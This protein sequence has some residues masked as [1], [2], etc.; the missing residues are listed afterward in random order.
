MPVVANNVGFEMSVSARKDGALRAAYVR[1][2]QGRVAKTR[3]IVE[4]VLLADY[5]SRGR[6]LGIEILAPVN[7][8]DVLRLVEPLARKAFQRFMTRAAPKKLVLL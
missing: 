5:D 4:D 6:L 7:L 8:S 1:L 2:S 3:E